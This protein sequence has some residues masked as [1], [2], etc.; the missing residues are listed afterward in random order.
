M[1][2]TSNIAL[3]TTADLLMCDGKNYC[4]ISLFSLMKRLFNLMI[5]SVDTNVCWAIENTNVTEE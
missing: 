1:A 2:T 4:Q 3:L 5:M